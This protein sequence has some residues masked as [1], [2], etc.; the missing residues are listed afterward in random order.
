MS[1]AASPLWPHSAFWRRSFAIAFFSSVSQR[2]KKD[3]RWPSHRI[4]FQTPCSSRY[5]ILNA[6]IEPWCQYSIL[7]KTALISCT[8]LSN[9][10]YHGSGT[11]FDTC[12]LLSGEGYCR[13]H[14]ASTATQVSGAVDQK[15]VIHGVCMTP[16]R[17]AICESKPISPTIVPIHTGNSQARLILPLYLYLS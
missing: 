16:M 9:P 17:P 6:A 15:A 13:F 12:M 10:A 1:R 3:A 2:A 4:P 7:R 14:A 11:N 5:M 8:R